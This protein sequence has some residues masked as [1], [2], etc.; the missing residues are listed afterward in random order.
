MTAKRPVGRPRG[1]SNKILGW[2]GVKHINAIEFAE[3]LHRLGVDPLTEICRMINLEDGNDSPVLGPEDRMHALIALLP[4]R[5]P[6]LKT[7]EIKQGNPFEGMN[8]EQL[9]AVIQ[10]LQDDVESMPDPENII[11]VSK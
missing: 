7:V 1:P 4:Y 10:K 2:T 11:E 8:K 3:T 6:K 9:K 5:Y